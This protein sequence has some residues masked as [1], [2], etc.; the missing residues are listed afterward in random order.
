MA[1]DTGCVDMRT[2]QRKS[3]SGVTEIGRGPSTGR[4]TISTRVAEIRLHMVG[5]AGRIEII[6]VTRIAVDRRAR[7]SGCMAGGAGGIDM[8]SCQ[9]KSRVGVVE[10]RRRP[11]IGRMADGAILTECL[12]DMIR[13]GDRLVVGLMAIVASGRSTRKACAMA[14]RTEQ[15]SVLSCQ[16][17]SGV[18]MVK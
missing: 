4:V 14:R 17:E 16:C 13:V 11:A 10:G 5:V 1:R 12:R 15:R 6:L 9:R 8:F 18:A 7:V 2:G 3:G